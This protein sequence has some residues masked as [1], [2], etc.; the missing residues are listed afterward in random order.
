[1]NIIGLEY[2]TSRNGG[3]WLWPSNDTNQWKYINKAEHWNFPFEISNLCKNKNLVIQAGGN[4]GIYPRHYSTIFKHVVTF[5]PDYK[6]FTC[7]SVNAHSD[8]VIKIQA[9]LGASKKNVKIDFPLDKGNLHQGG[10]RTL[11]TEGTIPLISIDE[12]FN[13]TPDLIHLDIEGF[14][15][16]ALMGMV[17]TIKKSK[18]I[19]VLETNGSGDDYGWPEDKI[20]SLMESFG[21]VILKKWE[22]DTAFGYK[23]KL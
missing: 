22:H 18:P 17:D 1:M 20:N 4:A 5:E 13:L 3:S 19:I 23:E 2:R 12:S 14:E 21:Y 8:N 9:C 10:I 11:E 16:F 7:L 6:N 15:A